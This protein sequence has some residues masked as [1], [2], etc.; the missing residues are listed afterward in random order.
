M[1]VLDREQ[2]KLVG[3][4]RST[5][6]V[7]A[8]LLLLSRAGFVHRFFLGAVPASSRSVYF[9]SPLGARLVGVPLRGPRRRNNAV[10][11]TDSFVEHQFGINDIYCRVKYQPIAHEGAKLVRWESFPRERGPQS[12][13]PD[14]YFEVMA[15]GKSL[16]AFLEVDLGHEGRAVWRAKVQ[17]YLAYMISGDFESVFEQPGFR[18]LAVANSDTRLAT[19]RRETASITDKVFWF[20]T[21][22]SIHRDGFW[23]SIWYRPKGDHKQSLL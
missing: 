22:D 9:L 2:A 20:A 18:V 14:G 21:S 11:L 16:A 3:G 4:F 19:L 13:I 8:R 17:K 15:P 6:R 7:N 5:R 12:L 1:R 10:V 23:S